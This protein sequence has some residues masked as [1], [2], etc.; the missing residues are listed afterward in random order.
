MVEASCG[1]RLAKKEGLGVE[2]AMKCSSIE[3]DSPAIEYG[4]CC[5][6]CYKRYI[7]DDLL[8]LTKEAEEEWMEGGEYFKK[9]MKGDDVI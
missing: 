9:W 8:L 4:G 6:K 2:Y 3:D 5:F 7:E 1:H